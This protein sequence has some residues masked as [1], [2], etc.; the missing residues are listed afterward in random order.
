MKDIQNLPDHRRINI[1]KV[2]VKDIS[3]PIKVLDKARDLYQRV[4]FE[5]VDDNFGV[6]RG[7]ED[8]HGPLGKGHIIAP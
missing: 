6:G 4:I 5:Y 2:G 3:Y 8:Q 7:A 1:K